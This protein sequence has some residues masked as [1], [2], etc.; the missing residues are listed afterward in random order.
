MHA[1]VTH[2]RAKADRLEEAIAARDEMLPEIERIQGL[3][4]YISLWNED[5]TGAVIAV[6]ES[7]AAA[8]ASAAIAKDM[9][10]RFAD[11]LEPEITVH[12][13]ANGLEISP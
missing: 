1:R 9:W 10:S 7:A 3:I 4:R 13:F 8:E 6:Y 12:A 5:G 2:Y 11:L